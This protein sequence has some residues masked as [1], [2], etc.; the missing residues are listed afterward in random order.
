ML[1]SRTSVNVYI[2]LM[3][4]HP[5]QFFRHVS[6]KVYH[7]ELFLCVYCQVQVVNDPSDLL[8]VPLH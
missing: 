5:M 1:S 7:E 6:A 8:H 2:S 3:F 4:N